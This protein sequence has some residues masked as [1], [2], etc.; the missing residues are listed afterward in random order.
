MNKNITVLLVDDEPLA[1][2]GMRTMLKG[3]HDIEIIGESADGPQAV[4]DIVAK[5]PDL[6]FLD[7]QMPGL[8]GFGVLEKVGLRRMPLTIFVT[9]YD[10]HALHAFQVH[11]IDYLLKPIDTEHLR[12]AL[13]RARAMRQRFET[14]E[15]HEKLEHLI[16]ELRTPRAFPPRFFI[17]STGRTTIVKSQDIEWCEAEDDYVALYVR[18]KKHLYSATIGSLESQLDPATFIRIHR[19]VIVNIDQIRELKPM[20]NGDQRMLL[21]NGK[22]LSLSRTYRKKVLET[23]SASR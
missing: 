8:D 4:K 5:K 7:V 14:T 6:V 20:F 22:E 11:A 16:A 21:K 2:K 3:S 10:K 15:M 13:E 17:K 23:I 19:S 1:R 18:G 9:A 12:V